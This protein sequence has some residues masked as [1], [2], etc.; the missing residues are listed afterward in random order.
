MPVNMT[1]QSNSSPSQ[2]PSSNLPGQQKMRGCTAILISG[3]PMALMVPDGIDVGEYLCD[4]LP[5]LDR[6][7]E[8]DPFSDQSYLQRIEINN[9]NII[10]ESNGHANVMITDEMLENKENEAML[11]ETSDSTIPNNNRTKGAIK[12]PWE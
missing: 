6:L 3:T 11:E 12:R 9:N 1:I 4:L 10:Y 2:S 7:F 8:F 5:I